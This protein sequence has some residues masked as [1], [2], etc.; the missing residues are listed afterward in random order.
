MGARLGAVA[1]RRRSL[2][3]DRVRVALLRCV[4]S[5]SARCSLPS[6]SLLTALSTRRQRSL[7]YVVKI[8]P[9]NSRLVSVP[10]DDNKVVRAEV[11]FGQRAGE[12]TSK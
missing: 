9:P 4:R 2:R 11:C 12:P 8:D 7:P 6:R 3:P 5:L 1:Q 10:M